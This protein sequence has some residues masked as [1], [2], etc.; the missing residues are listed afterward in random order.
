VES[1]HQAGWFMDH[2]PPG[3]PCTSSYVLALGTADP[4][5]TAQRATLVH[6]VAHKLALR[7]GD[8]GG[9]QVY[10]RAPGSDPPVSRCGTMYE[11][12]TDGPVIPPPPCLSVSEPP[13]G[14]GNG[15]PHE[16]STP[17][18]PRQTPLLSCSQRF[19]CLHAGAA[20][21]TG[22]TGLPEPLDGPE[23][24]VGPARQAA[25]ALVY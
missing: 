15:K 25:S 22:I 11:R 7:I 16:P 5:P 10:R 9:R 18:L 24:L 2:R 12:H 23:R 14:A 1:L 17:G 3:Y 20:R 6:F 4:F 8:D 13:P 21:R 19:R